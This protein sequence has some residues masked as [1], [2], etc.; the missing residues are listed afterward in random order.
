MAYSNPLA[1]LLGMF[2][3]QTPD[4]YQS[5]LGDYYDPKRAMLS[6]IGGN[7]QG[8]GMGL[9]S[10]KP[11]AW[12]IGGIQGGQDALDNY[13]QRAVVANGLDMRK[14]E[15]DYQM[16]QR[17][18]EAAAQK[19]EAD[20]Q[21]AAIAGLPPEMRS[22]A[23]AFPNAVIPNYVKNKFFPDPV[24]NGENWRYAT[25]EEKHQL[26]LPPD[27]PLVIGKS[28]PKLISTGAPTINVM[29]NGEP[30]DGKLRNK[31]AENEGTMWNDYQKGASVSGGMVQDLQ[32]LD[33]L[34][35]VAPQG[36][37]SGRLAQ[38]FPGFS[39]AGAAYQSIVSRVAPSLRAPGSGSTSDVE[40]NGFL[41]SLPRLQ[42][43]P[44]SNAVISA[45]LQ[46]KA[47]INIQRG[48]IVDKY[49]NGEIS[50][51]EAR[52]QLGELNRKSILDPQIKSLI[53]ATGGSGTTVD[54]VLSRYP[55]Q[56][57]Q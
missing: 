46:R 5:L 3:P 9:A 17:Q 35:K 31:L 57:Q 8:V 50:A 11:G 18:D 16:Q 55:D 15:Y 19:A 14:K 37:I 45:I 7:L 22:M 33:E 41:N 42:N 53:A 1:P 27:A 48:D 44:E 12:A 28:G 25:P 13:R 20:A 2:T 32:A 39:S 21:E 24:D 43:L 23:K 40:Y 47:Q 49:Q 51:V 38:T 4:A 29:P 36:P 34:S 56:P 26:G 10:G 30:P 6:M 54:D 52:K